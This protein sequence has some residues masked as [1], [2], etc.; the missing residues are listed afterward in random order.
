MSI[1]LKY[2]LSVVFLSIFSSPYAFLISSPNVLILPESAGLL[3][4]IKPSVI[5]VVAS[6]PVC[7]LY[8]TS[9][10]P[11]FGM[12]LLSGSVKEI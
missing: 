5:W 3:S 2:P 9:N 11:L 12:S 8:A 1:G 6:T 7:T 4:T 10:F